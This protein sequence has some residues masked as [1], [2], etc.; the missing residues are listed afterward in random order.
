MLIVCS[1]RTCE[2]VHKAT[3]C[4]RM[5]CLQAH[6][7]PGAMCRL[8]RGNIQTCMCDAAPIAHTCTCRCACPSI[9]VH[10]HMDTHKPIPSFTQAQ[11]ILTHGNTGHRQQK[12]EPQSHTI[13]HT[14]H[15]TTMQVTG[16]RAKFSGRIF[17]VG[18]SRIFF[19][20]SR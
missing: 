18:F 13:P 20:N 8:M 14:Q 2:V 10:T 4:E 5:G 15:C 6:N 16:R 11:H 1:C 3:M 7:T 9:H 12:A 19:T 17:R